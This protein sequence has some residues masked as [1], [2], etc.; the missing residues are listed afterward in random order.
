MKT[1]P[2]DPTVIYIHGDPEYAMPPEQIEANLRGQTGS[3]VITAI[4]A[5]L[6]QQKAETAAVAAHPNCANRD[7]AAGQ[8]YAIDLLAYDL[9]RFTAFPETQDGKTQDTR[10]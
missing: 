6:D 9:R 7:H 8:L 2:T 5:I 1:K 3:P 10:P 4:L